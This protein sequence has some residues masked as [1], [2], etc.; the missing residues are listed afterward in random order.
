MTVQLSQ[1]DFLRLTREALSVFLNYIQPFAGDEDSDFI[2]ELFQKYPLDVPASYDNHY[3]YDEGFEKFAFIVGWRTKGL[4][5]IGDARW[6]KRSE[7]TFNL[8]APKG[9]LPWIGD[10]G[11]FLLFRQDL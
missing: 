6:R 5:G 7:L 4:W 8:S 9:H 1:P 3:D 2:F 10:L 11:M